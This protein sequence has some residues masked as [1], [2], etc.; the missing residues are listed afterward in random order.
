MKRKKSFL[1][2]LPEQVNFYKNNHN[3]K[4][5]RLFFQDEAR[6]GRISQAKKIWSPPSRRME[7]KSQHIREYTYAYSALEPV[8]G[9]SVSLILPYATT[10]CMNIFLKEL[11][12]RYPDDHILLVWDGASWHRS[13]DLK[14]PANIDYVQLPPY[15][16]EL[17]PVEQLWK[18]LRQR[19]FHNV[20]FETLKAVENRLALALNYASTAVEKVKSFALYPYIKYAIST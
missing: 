6:F 19:F 20:Y 1:K 11:S 9:E 14:K 10:D 3:T 13:H 17:N 7:L 15:S 12:K 8:T 2:N 16:P 18:T 4:K 5:V